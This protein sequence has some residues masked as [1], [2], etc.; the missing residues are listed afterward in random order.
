[1]LRVEVCQL[2]YVF[3]VRSHTHTHTDTSVA[4][5]EQS[6]DEDM[7]GSVNTLDRCT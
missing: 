7:Y 1:M 2:Q 5:T 4:M 3:H 6:T